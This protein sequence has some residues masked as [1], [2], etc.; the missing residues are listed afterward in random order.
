MRFKSGELSLAFAALA[1]LFVAPMAASGARAEQA[2]QQAGAASDA[3]ET[4]RRPVP[5]NVACF[6]NSVEEAY[7]GLYEFIG[8]AGEQ[9]VDADLLANAKNCKD[10]R[11]RVRI[12]LGP[13]AKVSTN[14]I[15]VAPANAVHDQE[16]R[17]PQFSGAP[18]KLRRDMRALCDNNDKHP[19]RVS[20]ERFEYRITRTVYGSDWRL[21]VDGEDGALQEAV[22][23]DTDHY[24]YVLAATR[25]AVAYFDELCRLSR[26]SRN[27]EDRFEAYFDEA[28]SRQ[29]QQAGGSGG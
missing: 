15:A 29:M 21:F 25:S 4:G 6:G 14:L 19:R 9:K 22:D 24:R 2:Q 13:D 17:P 12:L 18:E 3:G 7:Q 11:G 1:M 16:S 10:Y 28:A 20:L 26:H 5:L 23:P 27:F 8:Y